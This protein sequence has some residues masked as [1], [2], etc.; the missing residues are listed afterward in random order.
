MY[1]P[2]FTSLPG[3]EICAVEL[4]GRERRLAEP[5]IPNIEPLLEAMVPAVQE[6][7]A[8]D[9]APYALFGH[10]MGAIIVFELARR[11]AAVEARPPSRLFLSS[12][13]APHLSS[14][15]T[16]EPGLSDDALIAYLRTLAGTPAELLANR[17]F[18]ELVLP[19]LRADLALCFTYRLTPGPTLMT[20]AVV[21]GGVSDPEVAQH[22]LEGWR[23][24]FGG[25]FKLSLF[26]GGHF[27]LEE[28][29][30]AVLRLVA[31]ELANLHHP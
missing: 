20:S 5:P 17:E 13:R 6:L 31:E 3:V 21:L 8:V 2:W 16:N 7:L 14:G 10:S 25:E 15:D 11:L 30:S 9:N 27:Y 29:R 26:P 22:E 23:R 12:F 4:P 18:L 24:H 19:T 1:R 28:C